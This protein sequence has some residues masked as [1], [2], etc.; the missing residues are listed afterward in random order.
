M[1]CRF[2]FATFQDVKQ[3]I[4][5]RGHLPRDQALAVVEQLAAAGFDK[6]TFA[7]GEPTLCPW[8]GELI[9]LAK[10]RGLVTML[11]TNGS[12]LLVPGWLNTN[13]ALLDWVVL[14]IDSADPRTH[15]RLGRSIVG[16]AGRALAVDHYL[17]IA[18]ELRRRNVRL[19]VNTVVT[20]ENA[21]EDM[22]DLLFALRPE[23]W[24]VLQ[25]LPIGGQNDGKVESL[26]IDEPT[27]RR[28]C[29]RH[30]RVTDAGIAIVPEDNE[31][32]TGSYAMV[33]PAGR[34]FDNSAGHYRYSRPILDAGLA[35]A[36][37]DIRF[38]TQ[39][40]E[41]RGGVYDWRAPADQDLVR[42]RLP[43]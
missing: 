41:E 22:G 18:A 21:D 29:A 7:G 33:D 23:R 32:M 12:R 4:L 35:E 15:E 13:G 34:F 8:L 6:I 17:A 9:E 2:C 3:T 10:Q 11:V 24:K 37:Q 36:W 42:L 28:Y 19:K 31:D 20:A 26:L 27:F 16:Q 5:P 30:Q 1:R 43:R 25:V 38:D 39:R 14:S 40:F